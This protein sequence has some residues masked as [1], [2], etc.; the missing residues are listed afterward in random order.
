MSFDITTE[1][2]IKENSSLSYG[3][4]FPNKL[5]IPYYSQKDKR[6]SA[7]KY[8]DCV[9]NYYQVELSASSYV[10]LAMV[11]SGLNQDVNINPQ[12]VIEFILGQKDTDNDLIMDTNFID[13]NL[14]GVCDTN[15]SLSQNFKSGA[16][17]KAALLSKELLDHYNVT[18]LECTGDIS[19]IQ[20][21]IDDSYVV[22]AKI[23][24]HSFVINP[25]N[26]EYIEDGK[27]HHKLVLFDPYFEYKNGLY[28]KYE[29]V[30]K[31]YCG[32]LVHAI[33]YKSKIKKD[34]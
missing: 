7:I 14:D 12:N 27:R 3:K 24:G 31:I 21:K 17:K 1:N 25:S 8:F 11:L 30:T 20:E 2:L 33:A 15:D 6:W 22:L 5:N 10:S 19:S 26:E 29:F 32:E 13:R 18:G 16:I 4:W 28:T 23:P 34:W 9:K